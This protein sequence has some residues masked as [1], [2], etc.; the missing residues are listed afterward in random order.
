MIPA[1]GIRLNDLVSSLHRALGPKRIASV[2]NS[3]RKTIVVD[4]SR[5]GCFFCARA[6]HRAKFPIFHG[7][8][9]TDLL[10]AVHGSRIPFE[11]A[12][13]FLHF[14]GNES[15][16]PTDEHY[17]PG[18]I[19]TVRSFREVSGSIVRA[20]FVELKNA[21]TPHL[22]PMGQGTGRARAKNTTS[23]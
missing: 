23:R 5:L 9:I 10:R 13:T 2:S 18:R 20:M 12:E 19:P 15:S 11:R 21:L 1:R 6:L 4:R 8:E 7:S 22:P 14:H 3:S 16:F 17:Y